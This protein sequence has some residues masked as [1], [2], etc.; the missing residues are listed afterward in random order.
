MSRLMRVDVTPRILTSPRVP[1][2]DR[3]SA[4]GG[5]SGATGASVAVS[6][7]VA[8]APSPATSTGAGYNGLK[9]MPREEMR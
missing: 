6:A 8:F 3:L 1:L 7:A 4:S 5:G 9:A 2:E